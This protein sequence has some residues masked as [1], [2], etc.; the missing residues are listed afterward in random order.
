MPNGGSD[1][2]G[3]C[4]FN[5]SL[6]G[7]RG[8]ANFNRET[9]S[10]CEIRDL[11]I[12]DSFYTYCANH[13]CQR[14]GRDPIPIG[15]V[16]VYRATGPSGEGGREEWQPS[17]DT[18]EIRQHLLDIVCLPE[19][20]TDEGYHFHTRPTHIEPL[21]Q[22]LEWRDGRL[23]PALEEIARRPEAER[24]RADIEE[25]IGL[26]R[27]RRG[28]GFEPRPGSPDTLPG[29]RDRLLE[30]LDD[31]EH[32]RM[33]INIIGTAAEFPDLA[34]L[35]DPRGLVRPAL[36]VGFCEGHVDG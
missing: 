27:E 35:L 19:E 32:E 33:D 28:W 26:V 18:E 36:G 12:P 10:H 15:P 14:P 31:L 22:L 1:C 13:P 34:E 7:Q 25:T 24:V 29:G 4:W 2:C 17:P 21:T 11:E 9:P 8:S 20:H 30:A 6:G 23:V 5:R 3:T 16:Y